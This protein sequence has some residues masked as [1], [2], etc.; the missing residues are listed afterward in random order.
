MKKKLALYCVVYYA[1]AAPLYALLFY[2]PSRL[3]GD[4]LSLGAVV[5]LTFATVFV[6]IPL[7]IAAWM[8]LSPLAWYVD[9]FAALEAPLFV[10]A[11]MLRSVGLRGGVINA[12]TELNATLSADGGEGWL[13]LLALFCFGLLLSFSF[14]RKQR[15]SLAYRI[16]AKLSPA[17]ASD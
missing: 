6:L 16:L 5:A 2:G 12:V 17:P 13:Y 4:D 8:R 9:P 10:Y 14:A 1:A 7:G 15:R 3:A 11:A